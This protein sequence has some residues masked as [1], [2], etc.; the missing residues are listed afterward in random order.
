MTVFVALG[1]SPAISEL[2]MHCREWTAPGDCC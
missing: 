1:N 2:W